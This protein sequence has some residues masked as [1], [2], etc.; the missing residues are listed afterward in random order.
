MIWSHAVSDQAKRH[1]QL[2][3]HV[4]YR[5]VRLCKQ[6]IACIEPCRAGA[7]DGNSKR[8]IMLGGSGCCVRIEAAERGSARQSKAPVCAPRAQKRSRRNAHGWWLSLHH[9]RCTSLFRPPPRTGA[10]RARALCVILSR[11]P[12]NTVDPNTPA[13][14]YSCPP[15]RSSLNTTDNNTLAKASARGMP[16]AHEFF[17]LVIASLV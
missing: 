15:S 4:H 14:P 7:D 9:G 1:W 3:I 10:N 2:F 16:P 8:S 12:D 11:R 17:P 5:I 13:Q 6:P